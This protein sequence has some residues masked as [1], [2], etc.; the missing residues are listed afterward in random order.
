MRAIRCTVVRVCEVKICGEG[1]KL[2]IGDERGGQRE[3]EGAI[4]QALYGVG[5]FF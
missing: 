3:C 2:A 5:F 1:A 4:L